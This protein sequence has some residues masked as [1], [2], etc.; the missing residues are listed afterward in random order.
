[1]RSK[2]S[3]NTGRGHYSMDL[4]NSDLYNLAPSVSIFGIVIFAVPHSRKL[5]LCTVHLLSNAVKIMLF[6]SDVQYY[7][8]IKLC[9]TAGCTHLFKI[10]GK[11][12]PEN[13]ILKWNYIW[14]IIEIEW[15]EVNTWLLMETK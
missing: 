5:K 15:K 6:I 8:P 11:L 14:D 7:V 10:T 4:Q 2:H 12:K 13:V 1:M 3:N 9:K